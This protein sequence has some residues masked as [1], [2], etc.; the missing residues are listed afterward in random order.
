MGGIRRMQ[1]MQRMKMITKT[2]KDAGD[3][4][5]AMSQKDFGNSLCNEPDV[6][7]RGMQ[8]MRIL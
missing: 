2:S 3:A 4:G 8:G 7:M 6:G 1:R 5:V